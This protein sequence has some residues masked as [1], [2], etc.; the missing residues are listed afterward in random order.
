MPKTISVKISKDSSTPITSC[1]VMGVSGDW[2]IGSEVDTEEL[3][4]IEM[5]DE[6]S[7]TVYSSPIQ[8]V[9]PVEYE[10]PFQ[11]YLIVFDKKKVDVRSQEYNE[12]GFKF[13]GQ[14]V[15]IRDS[16]TV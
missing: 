15:Q 2:I 6:K 7:D 5:Y 11:R 14:G 13:P 8:S 3:D 12:K 16:L 9:V 10:G 1:L 4:T